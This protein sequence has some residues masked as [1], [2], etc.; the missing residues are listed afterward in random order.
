MNEVTGGRMPGEVLLVGSLPF[1]V[2]EDAFRASAGALGG[3][4]ACLPDGEVGP[5][6]HWVGM[7][8]ALVFT[9]HP[10]IEETMAPPEHELEQP[11]REG[12][13]QPVEDLEGIWNFR[14][15]PGR[16]VRFDD[17]KYGRFATDSYAIFRRLRE[18]GVIAPGVRFQVSLPAPHSAIDGFFEDPGQWPELYRAYV[19]G[20]RREITTM[21]ETIPAGDLAIQWD[22]AWEF[23]DMAMG[24]R[25]FFRFWPKLTAEQKFQRHAEQLDELWQGIPEEA[26]LGFHWCYGTWGGW[27][28]TAMADLGLCVRMSN[29][30]K[31]RTRRRLD[32]VH[33]PVV[34][35][36]DEAF[37]APLDDLDVG[38]TRVFLGM[39]H[40]TD[41]IEDFRRRRDLAREHLA[42][43]GIG[44]VCGYGRVEP[45]LL[46]EILAIHAQDAD[47]L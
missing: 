16:S 32:W 12:E 25:N 38:D 22:V 23:V 43:F 10:D 14:V 45:E 30:A 1:D 24:E 36:P 3:H 29:E 35:K 31:R 13:R 37:F 42:D 20:L 4:V 6:T 33:M 28:M 18:E 21:L 5:R 40:H 11:D 39:V 26:L 46:P 44:S 27:P 9:E 19:D 15:K 17:L 8:A 2:A 47:E 41:A 34:R 7:L